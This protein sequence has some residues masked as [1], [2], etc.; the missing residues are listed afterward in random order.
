M[1]AKILIKLI[2]MEDYLIKKSKRF[3]LTVGLKNQ[4]SKRKR[5]P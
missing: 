1:R 5:F 3:L 4:R 2:M